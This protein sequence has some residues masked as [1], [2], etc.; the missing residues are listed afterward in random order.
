MINAMS[1]QGV[2]SSVPA[3]VRC[4]SSISVVVWA[5]LVLVLEMVMISIS[6]CCN[7]SIPI[8]ASVFFRRSSEGWV[9]S[10]S[11]SGFQLIG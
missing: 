6:A 7:Y 5:I 9:S 4:N 2:Q 8:A 3:V 1:G 10:L 11:G